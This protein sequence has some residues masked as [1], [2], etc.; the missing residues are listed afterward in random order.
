MPFNMVSDPRSLYIYSQEAADF[1][2]PGL[3]I[4]SIAC[5]CIE[6][7]IWPWCIHDSLVLGDVEIASFEPADRYTWPGVCYK[8]HRAGDWWSCGIVLESFHA[9]PNA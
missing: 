2:L 8:N 9:V 6:A 7:C 1:S 5:A 4:W 3:R